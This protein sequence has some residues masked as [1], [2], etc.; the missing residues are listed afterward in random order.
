MNC[1]NFLSDFFN[2]NVL[3]PPSPK[4]SQLAKC[5]NTSPFRILFAVIKTVGTEKKRKV[6]NVFR[7]SDLYFSGQKSS[8]AD[9]VRQIFS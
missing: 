8:L 1:D 4:I 2:E 3:I 5:L 9:P 6:R 7:S